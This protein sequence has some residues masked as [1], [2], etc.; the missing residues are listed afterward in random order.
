MSRSYQ[1]GQFPEYVNQGKELGFYS[2]SNEKLLKDFKQ[3]RDKVEFMVLRNVTMDSKG[4]RVEE[5]IPVRR[6]SQ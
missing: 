3:R 4:S 1:K 2:T 6:V 5:V